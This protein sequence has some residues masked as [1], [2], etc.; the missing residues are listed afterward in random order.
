MR[1]KIIDIDDDTQVG[2]PAGHKLC[3]K[4]AY[5]IPKDFLTL[6]RNPKRK[7]RWQFWIPKYKISYII[8]EK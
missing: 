6:G 7:S 5:R 4:T 8:R 1:D 3:V 2:I